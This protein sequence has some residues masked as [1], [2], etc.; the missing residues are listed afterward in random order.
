M[1]FSQLDRIISLEKG[2]SIIAVKSLSLSEEYLQDHFPR[3]PVMP[4]VLMI[5]SMFQASMFLVRATD[6]FN[7]S[8]V[9]MR[10]ANNFTFKGFVQPGDKLE[11][12]AEIKSTEDSFR[13][14]KVSGSINGEIASS[15]RFVIDSFN[16][17]ERQG[18]D[19]AIDNY[20]IR[21]FRL[22]FRRLCNQLEQSDLSAMAEPKIAAAAED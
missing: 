9:V 22:T 17:A 5:E 18:V 8:M 12:N 13:K 6:D 15:G 16:L 4:G 11:V 21:E 3:F 2:K 20:M 7:Y 1:R 14:I 19:P 10:E